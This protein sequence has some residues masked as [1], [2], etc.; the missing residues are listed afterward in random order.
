[1]LATAQVTLTNGTGESIS[2]RALIDPCSQSSF[3]PQRALDALG[4]KTITSNISVR[5]VGG[6]VTASSRKEAS[7]VLK[8]RD[9]RF[10]IKVT[11]VVLGKLTSKLPQQE[12]TEANWP[13][14]NHITLADPDFRIS[15]TIDC[16]VGGD[17]YNQIIME[18]LEPI[19]AAT[20][21]VAQKTK[22]GWILTGPVQYKED[23]NID[24]YAG[25]VLNLSLPSTINLSQKHSLDF[26]KLKKSQ[27]KNFLPQRNKNA[28]NASNQ[29]LLDW[30]TEDME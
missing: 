29:Q 24:Q 26:G 5:G 16:I 6:T 19:G 17:V 15:K 13:H 11:E 8:S 14:L 28:K 25:C 9:N 2:V 10:L 23:P 12:V 4:I 22:L 3:V 30:K 20:S 7:W 1:M 27:S 21:P 18:G